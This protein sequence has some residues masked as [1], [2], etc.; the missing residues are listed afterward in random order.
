MCRSIIGIG[1]SRIAMQLQMCGPNET[2]K[3]N[4]HFLLNPDGIALHVSDVV[5]DYDQ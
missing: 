5:T 4:S 1:A 3:S 2:T